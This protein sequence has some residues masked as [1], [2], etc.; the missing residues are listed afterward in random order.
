MS[1]TPSGLKKERPFNYIENLAQEIKRRMRGGVPAISAFQNFLNEYSRKK[2]KETEEKGHYDLFLDFCR[3][4]LGMD[5]AAERR[6]KVLYSVAFPNYAEKEMKNRYPWPRYIRAEFFGQ[7][8]EQKKG[9]PKMDSAQ[10]VAFLVEEEIAKNREKVGDV[11]FPHFETFKLALVAVFKPES[12]GDEEA[13]LRDAE[14]LYS[15]LFPK[16]AS[17]RIELQRSSSRKE[18][19]LTW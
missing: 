8:K 15:L 19:R 5:S 17:E 3:E 10:F 6:I 7:T 11:Q 16:E 9:E 13:L 14:F 1:E 18:T 2:I 4:E 12:R